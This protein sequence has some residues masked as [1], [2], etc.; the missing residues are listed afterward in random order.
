MNGK[1]M[2][3][4]VIFPLAEIYLTKI[5]PNTQHFGYQEPIDPS[6]VK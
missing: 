5:K 2:I 1:T 6:K 3:K 4:D